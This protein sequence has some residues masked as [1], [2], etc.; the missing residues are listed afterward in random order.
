MSYQPGDLQWG[1]VMDSTENYDYVTGAYLPH[2]CN[3]WVIGDKDAIRA[4][5]ADLQKLLDQ[6]K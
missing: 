2:S 3:E 4:L 5:I 1:E 6:P